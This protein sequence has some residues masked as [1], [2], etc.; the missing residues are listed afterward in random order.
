MPVAS[1]GQSEKIV[2]FT[3]IFNRPTGVNLPAMP[4]PKMGWNIAVLLTVSGL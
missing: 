4:P 2:H 1:N 3:L